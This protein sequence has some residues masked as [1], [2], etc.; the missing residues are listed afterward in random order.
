MKES[1]HED[2][3]PCD[4][5][6]S[7]CKDVDVLVQTVI[8]KSMVEAIPAPRFQD[9]LAYHSTTE[10]AGETAAQGNVKTLV[11]NHCVPPPAPGA[12]EEWITEAASNFSGKILVSE[13]LLR[14]EV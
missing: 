8:R 11:L 5:L 2:A 1:S 13:D 12:E 10:D 9:I 4:G 14:I 7:L 6:L 3:V